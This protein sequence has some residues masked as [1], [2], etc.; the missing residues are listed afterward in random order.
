MKSLRK[1]MGLFA[2]G[3]GVVSTVSEEGAIAATTVNSLTSVSLEPPLVL[4]CLARE[5]KTL[6]HLRRSGSFTISVLEE[7]HRELS[8]GLAKR[9]LPDP[10]HTDRFE[11]W[12]EHSPRI[13]QA[14]A[15][16]A[17]EVKEFLDGGDHEIVIGSVKEVHQ[18]PEG[19]HSP[20][21]YFRG[22]Y[23]RLHDPESS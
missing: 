4:V 8:D 9:G 12:D 19:E 2:T 23:A 17:C 7:D 13:Q 6:E 5:S 10:E 21:L 22:R 11:S 16:V 15:S 1:A 18:R 3:V 14:L 20:L